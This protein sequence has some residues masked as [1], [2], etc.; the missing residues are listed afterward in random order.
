MVIPVIIFSVACVI[1][2][3]RI[4]NNLVS[5]D[6]F[7]ILI[8]IALFPPLLLLHELLHALWFVKR[9]NVIIYASTYAMMSIFE[10]PIVKKSY[11]LSLITPTL[12]LSIIP[13]IIWTF[14]YIKN[15][16]VNMVWMILSLGNLGASIMDL[17]NLTQTAKIPNNSLI[18]VKDVKCYYFPK[19]NQESEE[20][21]E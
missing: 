19:T 11:V 18:M 14:V 4:T 15:P 9:T 13:L 10:K 5:T 3:G 12:V 2:K 16:L 21:V 7:M 20:V 8:S 6:L 17:Y 1:I